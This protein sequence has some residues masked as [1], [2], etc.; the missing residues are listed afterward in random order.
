MR[1]VY[2]KIPIKDIF[3]LDLFTGADV[4]VNAGMP[5]KTI[6]TLNGIMD[7]AKDIEEMVNEL[8]LPDPGSLNPDA[9]SKYMALKDDTGALFTKLDGSIGGVDI[10]NGI[11]AGASVFTEV[12]IGGSKTLRNDRLWIRAAPSVFFTI[13]YMEQGKAGMKGNADLLGKYELTTNSNLYM[14][15][16]WNL[17]DGSPDI[18]AS[19]GL[20]LTLEAAYALFP[21]LDIG[22]AVSHIPLVAS[23]LWYETSIDVN[24]KNLGVDMTSLR[25]LASNAPSEAP[26]ISNWQVWQ[27]YI[28]SMRGQLEDIQ[29]N[30]IDTSDFEDLNMEELIQT[31]ERTSY[32]V[33]RP[34]RFDVYGIFKPFRT[35]IL[36]VRPNA[37]ATVHTVF[38]GDDA[39]FNWGLNI[40]FNAPKIFSASI[41]TGVTEAVYSNRLGIA[42]DFRAFELDL[43][44]ALTGTTYAESFSANGLAAMVGMKFGW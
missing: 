29:K 7:T 21:M 22:M 25:S 24:A 34:T 4:I 30:G 3:T 35:P 9:V 2:V 17:K 31:G 5:E 44:A 41:G 6:S 27:N 42:L 32:D 12:G 20:D 18:F 13:L 36:V 10:P 40:Q 14:Y 37:G 26:S 19:P 8:D 33:R 16:A 39:L 1:P 38:A 28:T 15:S 23:T 11:E 43:G